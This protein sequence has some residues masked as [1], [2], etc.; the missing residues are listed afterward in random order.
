MTG[1]SHAQYVRSGHLVYAAA[2]TLRAVAFDPVTLVTQG[3]F[4]PGR[5]G[6]SGKTAP[7]GGVDAVVAAD[8]TLAYVSGLAAAGQR[9]LAWVDRQG[10]ETPIDA[11]PRAYA[12]PRIGPDGGRVVLRIADQ[13]DDLWVLDGVAPA[14]H[15]KDVQPWFR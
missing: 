10:L 2:N 5:F 4:G 7:A 9:T 15:A 12:L 13:Q 3:T 14:A 1:G 11:P 8:G 6:C